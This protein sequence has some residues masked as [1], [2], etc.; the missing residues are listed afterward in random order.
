VLTTDGAGG[1]TVAAASHDALRELSL[2]LR[3][4]AAAVLRTGEADSADSRG[5]RDGRWGALEELDACGARGAVHLVPLVRADGPSGVLVLA[6]A[7]ARV[8]SD[9]E[10]KFAATLGRL[11]G[12]AV[13]S[14]SPS[15]S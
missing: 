5:E 11:G 12:P 4:A 14:R 13:A 10:L 7:D 3:D 6:F 8:L 9:D 1:F 2:G 15:P